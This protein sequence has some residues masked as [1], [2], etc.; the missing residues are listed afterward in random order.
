[1]FWSKFWSGVKKK[2]QQPR[3]ARLQVESLECR[4][5]PAS[6]VIS[7]TNGVLSVVGTPGN[8]VISLTQDML[9]D[10]VVH[11]Q[12]GHGPVVTK[13]IPEMH[14]TSYKITT[15]AGNDTVTV[16][17]A[18]TLPGTINANS[19]GNKTITGG[20]GN[21]TIIT[22]S[23]NNVIFASPGH[24]VLILGSGKNSLVVG[25]LASSVQSITLHAAGTFSG[26]GSFTEGKGSHRKIIHF[27]VHGTVHFNATLGGTLSG[28][29]S[30]TGKGSGVGTGGFGYGVAYTTTG[31][32]NEGAIAAQ[33]NGTATLVDNAGHITKEPFTGTV[34][35]NLSL[36]TGIAG[37][38]VATHSSG[39]LRAAFTK[40][41]V[42]IS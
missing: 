23:G 41:L 22:G 17:S 28:N 10:V 8:D 15:G 4:I 20:G 18:I 7:V 19:P 29:F 25:S 27:T 13:T 35:A 26:S 21:D 40:I 32:V 42:D 12:S 6:P 5:V 36:Q 37:T 34:A 31:S 16:D 39:K 14:L 24:D 1:M 9:L 2:Q 3:R 38:W 30:G 33:I 11:A